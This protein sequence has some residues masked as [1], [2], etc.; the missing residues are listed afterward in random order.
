M[1]HL[2]RRGAAADAAKLLPVLEL[3]PVVA[4]VA[5]VVTVSKAHGRVGV[6]EAAA[7]HLALARTLV[8]ADHEVPLLQREQ[9]GDV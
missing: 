4:P 1:T 7:V 2:A 5:A 6:E 3:N 8:T 9:G